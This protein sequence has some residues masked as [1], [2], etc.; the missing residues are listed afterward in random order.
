M[1]AGAL[2]LC[3][4]GLLIP[5]AWGYD[6][7]TLGPVFVDQALEEQ[8]DY[9]CLISVVHVV[10]C[11]ILLLLL[12]SLCLSLCRLHSLWQSHAHWHHLV[13]AAHQTQTGMCISSGDMYDLQTCLLYCPVFHVVV[14]QFCMTTHLSHILYGPSLFVCCCCFLLHKL[15]DPFPN[16]QSGRHSYFDFLNF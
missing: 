16:W 5:W 12:L 14:P 4:G 2:L 13:P 11:L 3:A 7:T 1:S 8:T 9:Q 10:V 15:D 6:L